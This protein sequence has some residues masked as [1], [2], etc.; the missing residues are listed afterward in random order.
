MWMDAAIDLPAGCGGGG[1]SC[2][3]RGDVF[4]N[5]LNRFCVVVVRTE[6]PAAGKLRTMMIEVLGESE[7]ATHRLQY[8]LPGSGRVGIGMRRVFA[9]GEGA[10][11]VDDE[12]MEAQSPPP[13]TLPARAVAMAT[14]CCA[15]FSGAK[16][17]FR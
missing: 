16:K 10:D 7:I 8:M 1:R 12:A 2:P 5:P 13:M 17:E 3:A 15:Y 11:D 6:I 14:L 9:G 4:H